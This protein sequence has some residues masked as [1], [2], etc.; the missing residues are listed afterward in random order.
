M[1]E[2]KEGV[3]GNGAV[4]GGS[5]GQ[6]DPSHELSRRQRQILEVIREWVEQRG[7][8]PTLREIAEA[9]GLTSKSSVAHQLS[10][11]EKKGY[12]R[13]DFG[14]PRTVEMRDSGHSVPARL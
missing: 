10:T 1:A 11:L 9:V 14:R 13:R 4:E 6:P 2:R 5:P 8:A 12:L 7:Y 3:P